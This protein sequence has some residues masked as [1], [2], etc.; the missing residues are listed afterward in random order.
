M[1]ELVQELASETGHVV[2]RTRDRDRSRYR[3]DRVQIVTIL[4]TRRKYYS[5]TIHGSDHKP[6]E[7]TIRMILK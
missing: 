2:E 3:D 4:A 1:L 6:V 7:G 5:S